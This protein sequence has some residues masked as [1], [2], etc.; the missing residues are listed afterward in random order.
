QGEV[1]GHCRASTGCERTGEAFGMSVLRH[2][3][4]RRAFTLIELLIVIAI[5]AILVGLILPA[6]QRARESAARVKCANNLKQ[7]GLACHMVDG[8][9]NHLPTGGWGY[10]WVGDAT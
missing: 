10:R 7:I 2:R 4:R 8:T 3:P 9:Y 6:V 5:V 1:P